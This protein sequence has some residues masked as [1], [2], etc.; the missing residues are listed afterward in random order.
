MK[1]RKGYRAGTSSVRQDYREGGRVKLQIGGEPPLNY[2][3]Y[4]TPDLNIP[5]PK[6][7]EQEAEEARTTMVT[8]NREERVKRTG[9][10][11]EQIAQG[12]LPSS[13]S[14]ISTPQKINTEGTEIT[15]TQAV[16]LQVSETPTTIT[17]PTIPA[18]QTEQVTT[19][20]V[21]PEIAA[22]EPVVTATQT[23]SK[24]PETAVVESAQGSV[25]TEVSNA[26]SQ[27]AG[28]ANVDPIATASVTVT[29]GLLQERVVGT[30]SAEAKAQ[31]AKVAGTSLGR[32]TRAKKQLKNSGLTEAEISALGN[33]P[34]T[35]EAN[36][37]EFTEEERGI[38]EGLPEDALVS[39]QI[40]ALL[41]GIENGQ[42]PTWASP[43]V[44]SVEQMLAE[45]GLS[46]STVG[47]D[48]LLNAIITSALPIAQSNAQAIQNSVAQDKNIEATANIKNAELAQQTAMFNAQNVFAMDMAQF[49]ADQQRAVNNSKFL[50][51][52]ALTNASNEQQS[53]VQNAV[54]MSQRNLAEADQNTKLGIQNA[55]AFLQMDLTNL[56]NTQQSGILKAQQIQQ[57]LL[58]N[59]AAENAAEQFNATSQNQLNQFMTSLKSQT[60]QFNA[61]QSSA[62]NQFNAAAKNAAAA[63]DAQ[64]NAD[65]DKNNATM[66]L[67]VDQ[68]NNQQIFQREQFNVQNATAIAQSNVAWRRQANTA[69]TAAVNAVNQQN[70][71]NAFNLSAQAQ[72]NLWQELR[73]EADYTFKRW[74]NDEARKTSLMI[75]A[76]SNESG[77]TGTNNFS[78]NVAAITK[79][80]KDWLDL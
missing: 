16:D 72:A 28:V 75:A 20:D 11:T 21:V 37:L 39:T 45:R 62:M 59:Q 9:E 18:P 55:Q 78:T 24:V 49:D 47:R 65:V 10:Q 56:S 60:D 7:P 68:F 17:A 74:D 43:A 42:I 35:L 71:Q 79:L 38:I 31:A 2:N 44:S 77:T 14:T 51:T 58:S 1:K 50:Q 53:A 6:T 54:L 13:I 4:G 40:D 66:A 25:S 41:T 67:Q 32:I 15:P 22:P 61:Q 69:N 3:I 30:I 73:D 48:G 57:Q 19:A 80:A 12:N 29:P 5:S 34:E 70:A 23:V 33:D 26:L 64:R 27:A 63:R 52:V 36:L 76:L 8:E 46:A